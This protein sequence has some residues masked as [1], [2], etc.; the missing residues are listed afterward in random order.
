MGFS[1]FN[2]LPFIWQGSSLEIDY[3]N[4]QFTPQTDILD[5]ILDNQWTLVADLIL[6][7]VLQDFRSDED[8]EQAYRVLNK[9]LPIQMV[10]PW[11]AVKSA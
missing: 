2:F 7:E 10:S 6:A 5:A 1:K 4:S 11:P 3:L 9:F 8:V